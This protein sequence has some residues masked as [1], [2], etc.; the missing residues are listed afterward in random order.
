MLLLHRNLVSREFFGGPAVRTLPNQRPGFDPLVGK[1]G[2]WKLCGRA[3][4]SSPK[5][6][7]FSGYSQTLDS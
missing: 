3:P 5:K 2:S 6:F 1:L 4:H 7:C